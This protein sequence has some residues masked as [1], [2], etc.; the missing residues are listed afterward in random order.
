MFKKKMIKLGANYIRPNELSSLIRVEFEDTESW[1]P[2]GYYGYLNR[3]YGNYMELPPAYKQRG[4]HSNDNYMQKFS[5]EDA[6]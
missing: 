1:I 4:H 2:I 3:R 6:L 5:P